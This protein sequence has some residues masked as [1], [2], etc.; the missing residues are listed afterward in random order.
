M[1]RR[2]SD[3]K[4]ICK[5]CKVVHLGRH[6]NICECPFCIKRKGRVEKARKY[7]EKKASKLDAS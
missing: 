6:P 5:S 4:A 2:R 7:Q 1:M 3:P